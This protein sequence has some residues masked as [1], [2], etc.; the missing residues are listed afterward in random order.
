MLYFDVVCS[1]TL[2]FE[3]YSA[4]SP[5]VMIGLLSFVPSYQ[6]KMYFYPA[7]YVLFH[8]ISAYLPSGKRIFN[9]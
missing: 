1:K 6:N 4:E 5:I 8:L 7:E 9:T 2:F 3:T